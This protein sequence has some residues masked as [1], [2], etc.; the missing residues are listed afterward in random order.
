MKDSSKN[1]Y[2]II[3]SKIERNDSGKKNFIRFPFFSYFHLF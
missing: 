1:S 2:L 3:R